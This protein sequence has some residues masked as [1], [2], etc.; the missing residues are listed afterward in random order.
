MRSP[1][2][3]TIA[4]ICG[5][6]DEKPFSIVVDLGMYSGDWSDGTFQIIMKDFSRR[7]CV[8]RVMLASGV[9]VRA[10]WLLDTNPAT[11]PLIQLIR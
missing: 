6:L 8:M 7:I 11:L 5:P 10:I 9:A 2:N 4:S 1:G 3:I